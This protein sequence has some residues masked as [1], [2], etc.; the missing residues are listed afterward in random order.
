MTVKIQRYS[1]PTHGR[2]SHMQQTRGHPIHDSESPEVFNAN[3]GKAMHFESL[4][5]GDT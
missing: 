4:E 1:M 2:Q 3:N 5:R